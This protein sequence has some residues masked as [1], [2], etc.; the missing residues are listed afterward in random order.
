MNVHAAGHPAVVSAAVLGSWFLFVAVLGAAQVRTRALDLQ[1]ALLNLPLAPEAFERLSR[2]RVL[3]L[4]WLP[5]FDALVLF[6]VLAGYEAHTPFAWLAVPPL[7]VL[8]GTAVWSASVWLARYPLPPMIAAGVN[9]L[10]FLMLLGVAVQGL[11]DRLIGVLVHSAV[12][13]SLLS[14][15]GWLAAA[16]LGAVGAMP[17]AWLMGLVPA[18]F[19]AASGWGAL[20]GLVGQLEPEKALLALLN[21]ESENSADPGDDE[22]GLDASQ[23]PSVQQRDVSAA[24]PVDL[25]EAWREA[26]GFGESQGC[27]ERWFLGWLDGRERL[28]LEC[29]A[30]RVPAWTRQTVRSA[31]FLAV[32]AAVFWLRRWA[33]PCLTSVLSW[34]GYSAV[35]FGLLVGLPL[36]SGFDEIASRAN[37]YGV[38]VARAALYPLR[39]TEF[40]RLTVKSALLRGA[41]LLPVVVAAACALAVPWG[42]PVAAA[43]AGG[44]KVV[45]LSVAL[46]PCQCVF[47]LSGVSN[48][49]RTRLFCGG[50]LIVV[51]MVGGALV[52]FGLGAAII[53]AT[54]TWSAVAAFGF[55]ALAW[56]MSRLYLRAYERG[57]F[58]LVSDA[59][60]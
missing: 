60:G 53:F 35:G 16:F 48:D 11:R 12:P 38:Q 30:A 19:W 26:V 23:P 21:R 46:S 1:P 36:V 50:C 39:V 10:T 2:G 42:L 33:S 31:Q 14:P 49:T 15:G 20:K 8:C 44:A 57:G 40:T 13:L 29:V 9:L 3:G 54:W 55:A 41:L 59:R 34:I 37:V 4:L 28:V 25:E 22:I 47:A 5:C 32:G 52:L 6:G 51:L 17:S 18:L 58:D 24:Q 43:A 7:A 27:V 45:F 56:L